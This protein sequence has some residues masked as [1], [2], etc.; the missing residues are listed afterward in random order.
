MSKRIL[1][2]SRSFYPENSPRANRTTELA[3]EFARQ[4]HIVTILTP[5]KEAVHASF[6][7]EYDV[8]IKD[9][10][11]PH[12]KNPDFGKSKWGYLLGLYTD[13]FH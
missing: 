4:G 5:R 1:I 9:L 13:S 2:I 7:K 8:E 11:R 12:W 10:G 3:K 6:E